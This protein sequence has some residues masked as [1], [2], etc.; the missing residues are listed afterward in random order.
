MAV[1]L[2]TGGNAGIGLETCVALAAQGRHVVF[3]SRSSARGEAARG[4]IVRRSGS[5]SVDVMALDLASF[6]SVHEFAS[7]FL[8]RYDG[9]GVVIHNAGVV[10]SSRQVTEDGNETTFQVNHLGP[11]LLDALLRER[12]IASGNARVVVVASDAHT[13]ARHGLD[14]EDLQTERRRYSSFA[15]YGR[16]KLANILF[17]R[18]L[19]RRLAG[20]AVT[21][22]AVHPGFVATRFARDGDTGML[23]RLVMPLLRPFALSPAQGAQTSVYVATAPE[24]EGITGGYWVKN[25]PAT[26]SASAQDDAAAR[27]LWEV[28]E[29]L[30]GL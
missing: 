4:V 14:F 9:V 3:T 8:D 25:A 28:S 29:R 22:N 24:L 18:E 6:A 10:L 16:T 30:T 19:T 5:E 7:V 11:F 1:D 17:T 13:S 12:V 20:T 15:V 23:G 26:P 27:R 2:V 21:A